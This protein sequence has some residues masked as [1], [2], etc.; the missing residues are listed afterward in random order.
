MRINAT[1]N[2]SFQ[3]K[4]FRLIVGSQMYVRVGTTM[5]NFK[6]SGRYVQ[7]YINPKAEELYNKAQKTNDIKEKVRL[8]D[9]MGHYELKSLNTKE[10]LRCVLETFNRFLILEDK[11][12]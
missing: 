9:K 8:Y 7:E 5:T 3:A 12:I 10:R 11:L 1:D 4:K 2:H 6:T